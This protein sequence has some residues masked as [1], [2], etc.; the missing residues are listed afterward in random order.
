MLAAIVRIER[1]WLIPA[2]IF[3]RSAMFNVRVLTGSTSDNGAT[4]PAL[5]NQRCPVRL[6]IPRHAEAASTLRPS[7]IARQNRR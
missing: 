2:R 3:S 1:P 6:S 7:R 5:L 4:P